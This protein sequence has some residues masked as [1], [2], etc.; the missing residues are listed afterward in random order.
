MILALSVSPETG[1]AL[2]VLGAGTLA[3]GAA[4][5]RRAAS[6]AELGDLEKHL[7]ETVAERGK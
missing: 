5:L 2:F 3:A 4:A 1:I 6:A 7:G